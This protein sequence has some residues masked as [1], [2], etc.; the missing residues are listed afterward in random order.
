M[1]AEERHMDSQCDSYKKAESDHNRQS[2]ESWK[3]R[4]M[5]VEDFISHPPKKKNEIEEG[6]KNFIS[7]A[8]ENPKWHQDYMFKELEWETFCLVNKLPYEPSIINGIRMQ[9][10]V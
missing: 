9:E 1:N 10:Q 2:F 4:L 7:M 5:R 6:L 8:H 3:E